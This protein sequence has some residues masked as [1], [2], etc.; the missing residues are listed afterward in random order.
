MVWSI[1]TG[2]GRLYGCNSGR[3][4]A[5]KRSR[6]RSLGILEARGG[7]C[8][9]SRWAQSWGRGAC[10][11]GHDSVSRGVDGRHVDIGRNP[12]GCQRRIGRGQGARADAEVG[13]GVMRAALRP[14]GLA[15][16]SSAG[17]AA[18]GRRERAF[19]PSLLPPVYTPPRYCRRLSSGEQSTAALVL[20]LRRSCSVSPRSAGAIAH[21]GQGLFAPGAALH[22][23]QEPCV[24]QEGPMPKMRGSR[25]GHARAKNTSTTPRPVA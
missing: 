19:P 2:P 25:Q 9:R 14:H 4:L 11:A 6:G 17:H 23:W 16:A 12:S 21:C 3:R 13:L 8:C 22:H 5:Q 24:L 18:L 1:R 10:G 15:P 7:D 20:S